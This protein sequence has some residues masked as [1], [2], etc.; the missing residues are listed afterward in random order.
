MKTFE[1]CAR[2]IRENLVGMFGTFP[3]PAV[4]L[5]TH[6]TEKKVEHKTAQVNNE[7]EGNEK[8]V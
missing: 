2:L 6:K 3:D 8:E 1:E 4:A 5:V 7:G